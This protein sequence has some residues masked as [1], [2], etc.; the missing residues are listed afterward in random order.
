MNHNRLG[1]FFDYYAMCLIKYSSGFFV[2]FGT[3]TLEYRPKGNLYNYELLVH[4]ACLRSGFECSTGW[5][6]ALEMLRVATGLK[7]NLRDINARYLY[8]LA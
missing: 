6:K 5:M 3:F 2:M 4:S 1:L 8:L 7:T